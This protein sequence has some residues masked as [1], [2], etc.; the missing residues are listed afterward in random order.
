MIS[1]DEDDMSF[2]C[3]SLQELYDQVKEETK[4][5]IYMITNSLNEYDIKDVFYSKTHKNLSYRLENGNT[6]LYVIQQMQV[7]ATGN[8]T[9]N[10]YKEATV[11]VEDLNIEADIYRSAQDNSLKCS[12]VHHNEIL[13]LVTNMELEDYE[14]IIRSLE[15]H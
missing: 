1:A 3:N 14:T 9:I 10:D 7:D 12:I 4:S 13:S 15:Y 2:T 5:P 8:G 11:Y 6:Y